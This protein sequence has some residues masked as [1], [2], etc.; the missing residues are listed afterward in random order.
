DLAR[1]GDAIDD[2]DEITGVNVAGGDGMLVDR[3]RLIVVQGSPAQLSIVK[4]RRGAS[5]ATL[6]GTR[7]SPLLTGP[8]TL[9]TDEHT[10]LVVNADFN[11]STKPFTV[12]GLP[13]EDD[14][15]DD[16]NHQGNDNHGNDNPPAHDQGDDHG[17][18]PPNHDAGDDHGDDNDD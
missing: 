10:Y 2:I 1:S 6:D 9:A 16:D 17:D 8:S 18:D 4:L 14:R 12:A 5:A 3:G 11:T 13:R 7:T 15:K